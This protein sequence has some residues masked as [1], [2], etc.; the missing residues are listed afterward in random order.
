LHKVYGISLGPGDPEL[1]TLRG[2]KALQESDIIFYPGSLLGDDRRE[3]YVL[4]MLRH[5]QLDKP[6]LRGFFLKMSADRS[7]AEAT[8]Q[9]TAQQVLEANRQ[10]KKVSIV[11]EGDL[12]F[13]ASFSYLLEK[14]QQAQVPLELVPGIN[15]FSLGAARHQI[16][17]CLQNEKV[18]VLPREASIEAVEEMLAEFNT[19]L[20]MKIR[21]GWARLSKAL[22]H[23][24]WQCY[25]CERLG[26]AKEFITTDLSVLQDREIPY[27]SLLIIKR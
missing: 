6:K 23:K 17:L 24:D 11:C 25:Y 20:L 4:P 15:S 3:S 12:S 22:M 1:I 5:Y 14:L 7:A 21:S 18:A 8:Y 13:Y 27:F 19:L 26:T 16:P 9:E 10:G 2:L